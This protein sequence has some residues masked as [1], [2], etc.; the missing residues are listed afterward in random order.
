MTLISK[1]ALCHQLVGLDAIAISFFS[2]H[3][4]G[5]SHES[6]MNEKMGHAGISRH[7]KSSPCCA[8]A[9]SGAQSGMGPWINRRSIP[10]GVNAKVG[11][12]VTSDTMAGVFTSNLVVDLE[13]I[14]FPEF[15]KNRTCWEACAEQAEVHGVDCVWHSKQRF[16]CGWW[17]FKGNCS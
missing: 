5:P 13:S 7:Q 1:F 11:T 17:N 9:S 6:V 16:S 2:P 12:T 3:R 15:M 4:C 14:T 10:K 8:W